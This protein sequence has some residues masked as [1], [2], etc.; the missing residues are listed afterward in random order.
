[1]AFGDDDDDE[2]DFDDDEDEK[3]PDEEDEESDDD[4]S[5]RS[6]SSGGRGSSVVNRLLE[7]VLSV[8][9]LTLGQRIGTDSE[10]VVA[11]LDK[12]E[13]VIGPMMTGMLITTVGSMSRMPKGFRN[14]L[15]SK[16]VPRPVVNVLNTLFEDVFEGIWAARR[17]RRAKKD[18]PLTKED[19]S[20]GFKNSKK[21]L[22]E[23]AQRERT[24]LMSAMSKADP[25]KRAEFI[26]KIGTMS[27]EDRKKMDYYRPLI[28]EA[29]L[30]EQ[31]SEMD[32]SEW[33]RVLEVSLGAPPKEKGENKL[34]GVVGKLTGRAADALSKGLTEIVDKPTETMTEMA[35]GVD[36]VTERI[37]SFNDRLK[38]RR[39]LARKK[40]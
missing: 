34:A 29:W 38:A 24:S 21:K 39:A 10:S 40:W 9:A 2:D 31:L 23:K 32:T 1:M 5:S 27:P 14:A 16:G 37:N 18:E 36:Q 35:K 17:I 33:F 22:E 13:A 25:A 20:E 30:I 15:I 4:E 28:K 3:E 8:P 7:G 26:R 12:V 11:L 6:R 19:V